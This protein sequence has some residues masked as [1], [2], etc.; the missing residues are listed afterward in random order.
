MNYTSTRLLFII[1]LIIAPLLLKGQNYLPDY[2]GVTYPNLEKAFFQWSK[3]LDLDQTKGW[4]W[5]GRW[6]NHQTAR[7]DPQGQ[8]ADPEVVFEELLTY[9]RYKQNFQTKASRTASWTPV[10]PNVLPPSPDP[11]MQQGMGRINTITFH[12]TDPNTFW[13][14][15]AQGGLWKTTNSGQSWLPL[16]NDLPILRISDIAVDPNNTDVMYLA[17]GD[18]AYLGVAL[19]LDARKRHTHYGLGVYKS[20]NGGQNWA[21][22]GLGYN[23]T[24]LDGSLVRRVFIDPANSD[25]LLAGGIDGMFQSLNGGQTWTQVLD[26]L[27]WDMEKHPADPNTIY[28]SS[29]YVGTLSRGEAS[30]FKSTDFGTTWTKLNTNMPPQQQIQRVELAISSADPDYVYALT[31]N[32]SGGFYGL[33]RSTNGGNSWN[34]QS[35]GSS[36][37]NILHWSDGVNSSSGQGTYD[38]TILVDPKD[39]DRIYTGGINIWGSDDGGVNWQPISYW[40]GAY[41]RSIHADQ[42]FLAYNSLDEKIYICNDGGVMRTSNMIFGSWQDA[43]TDPSYTWPTQWEDISDGMNITSFYRL[44]IAETFTD[45]LLAGSQDNSTFYKTGNTWLGIIGG[46][47]MESIVH[48]DNQGTIYG[49]W[50]YG[51]IARST[52]GAQ[53]FNYSI[54]DP[55]RQTAGERGAWTTPY[56]LHPKFSDSMYTALGNLWISPN[57]GDTWTKRSNFSN[58]NGVSFPSPASYMEVSPSDPN[59]IYVAKRIYHAFGQPTEMWRTTDRGNTWTD[60]TAGLPDSLYITYFAIDNDDPMTVWVVVGG[61]SD[62]NKVYKTINGGDS[63]N[64]ISLNLPN[65]PV[66]TIVHDKTS[67]ENLVYI[68]MDRGVWYTADSLNEWKLFADFLPNVIV[69]ELAIQYSTSKIYAA[70]FGRGV[71]ESNLLGTPPAS[72]DQNQFDDVKAILYPNPGQGDFNLKLSGTRTPE[73][74]LSVIDITGREVFNQTL[75]GIASER[76]FSF[77][78][79]LNPGM[80]FLIL[81][82][83]KGKKAI[84]FVVE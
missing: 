70:T 49:S 77:S 11:T 38:L 42:H 28:A 27:I 68:G 69:S 45:D 2:K 46:D 66:N 43:Y 80:Y 76:E 48:P 74:Q 31:C 47:G 59:T 55:I 41:G 83:D 52:D 61:F 24:D 73:V 4:K 82:Q 75:T 79:D 58:M 33:Y 19:E 15:V 60:I 10:G 78:W 13:V 3:D 57:G 64:N 18:Y 1:S 8:P 54:T 12:P 37:E 40:T 84:R 71:W 53:S 20:T 50:Q 35:T 30:V 25:R 7:L 16:N 51:G 6:L 14:G 22:T 29:G 23:Q 9:N 39:K 81:T 56:Q 21:P 34:L 5:Y 62:G 67:D 65:L 32:M 17:V 36:S 26:S 44:S 72:L 63:W